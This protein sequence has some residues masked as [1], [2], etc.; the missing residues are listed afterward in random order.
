[1]SSK[2]LWSVGIAILG[3]V[4]AISFWYFRGPQMT[5][6]TQDLFEA[7]HRRPEL[8]ATDSNVQSAM[9]N[10]EPFESKSHSYPTDHDHLLKVILD[11]VSRSQFYTAR[12]VVVIPRP[13]DA[14]PEDFHVVD[15]IAD[16][17]IPVSPPSQDPFGNEFTSDPFKF[18]L[19]PGK[20]RVRYLLQ[21]QV[22]DLE[23]E[24]L[25]ETVALGEGNL[26]IVESEEADKRDLYVPLSEDHPIL[27]PDGT[28]Q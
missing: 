1:M 11:E 8:V 10:D 19:K 22:M 5:E 7:K 24:P 25:P 15:G 21:T 6:A 16:F 3:F 20:Y 18:R 9:L 4:V 28:P 27:L 14:T 23:N 26:T 13:I 17:T 12:G 2:K